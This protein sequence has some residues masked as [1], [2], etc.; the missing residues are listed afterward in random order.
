MD[1]A[2]LE[3]MLSL[4]QSANDADAVMGLHGLQKLFADSGSG[5]EDAIIYA[6]ENI[7]AL[8]KR[9]ARVVDHQAAVPESGRMPV[10]VSG[11]PQCRAPKAGCVE[12]IVPGSTQGALVTL[13]GV[14]AE[15]ADAVA[16]G[17]KDALVA[18]VINKSRF[19]LKLLDVKNK[20]GETVETVLQAEYDRDGMSP[21]RVWVNDSKGEVAALAAVLRKAVANAL[22]DLV[23]A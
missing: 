18:A 7:D 17:L 19:K 13:P 2:L 6:A 8:R 15:Q 16:S 11:M 3:K 14:A 4:T 10:A 5:L 22:P 23:A 21:V 9:A 20:K 12:I 1:E